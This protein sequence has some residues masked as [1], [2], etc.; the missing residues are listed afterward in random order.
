MQ[1]SSLA[2]H[3]T[4]I[5]IIIISPEDKF[6]VDAV[7]L[8]RL[9][10][11]V[12]TVPAPPEGGTGR[13]GPCGGVPPLQRPQLGRDA[14]AGADTRRVVV[15]EEPAPVFVLS[16]VVQVITA[17]EVHTAP[18]HYVLTPLLRPFFKQ[19]FLRLSCILIFVP[20]ESHGFFLLLGTARPAVQVVIGVVADDAARVALLGPVEAGVVVA[21]PGEGG[22]RHGALAWEAAQPLPAH[23]VE[24]AVAA[25]FPPGVSRRHGALLQD[26]HLVV[27]VQA[28]VALVHTLTLA[29]SRPRHGRG[30][31]PGVSPLAVGG[32]QVGVAEPVGAPRRLP[33][34][35][36]AG[37]SVR[38][39]GQA[40]A[41]HQAPVDL[42]DAV[43]SLRHVLDGP[44]ALHPVV[45]H[46]VP[47][48]SVAQLLL[49][50]C[51]SLRSK[52]RAERLVGRVRLDGAPRLEVVVVPVVV[53]G[54]ARPHAGAQHGGVVVLHGLHGAVSRLLNRGAALLHGNSSSRTYLLHPLHSQLVTNTI[55]GCC[56]SPSVSQFELSLQRL[57]LITQYQARRADSTD[58]TGLTLSHDY[59]RLSL[60]SLAFPATCNIVILY[61]S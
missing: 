36:V 35:T 23:H 40:G 41:R 30:F 4:I 37:G 59:C 50:V 9:N 46:H 32:P 10:L 14:Q 26:V 58:W 29:R 28:G 22:D 38:G 54:R 47:V 34:S 13:T 53:T 7:P 56:F 18:L 25:V 60:H 45:S 11:T 6:I 12:Q 16:L 15:G 52:H 2:N 3:Y 5:I 20:P 8:V 17:G 42:T 39:P 43:A 24:A 44:G 48:G 61:S 57:T 31:L 19:R 1:A 51:G 27:Q 21:G 49:V 33:G 55:L